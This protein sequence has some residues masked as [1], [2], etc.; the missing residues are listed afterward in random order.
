MDGPS[1]REFTCRAVRLKPQ[2]K[3]DG[4]PVDVELRLDEQEP[5][6]F[7]NVTAIVLVGEDE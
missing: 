4:G 3:V 1:P 7:T 5:L 6:R 2:G